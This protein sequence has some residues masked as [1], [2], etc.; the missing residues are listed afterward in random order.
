MNIYYWCPF[1]SNVATVKAVL[2]SA[3]SIKKYSKNTIS[4][5]IINVVGE[6]NQ[7]KDQI[8]KKKHQFN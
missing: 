3:I 8:I 2:N 6:W 7:L 5:H 4:P 1:L